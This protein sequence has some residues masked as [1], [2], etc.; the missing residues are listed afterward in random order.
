MI[1]T[2]SCV[3]NNFKRKWYKIQANWTHG[4]ARSPPAPAAPPPPPPP[5]HPQPLFSSTPS[6]QLTKRSCQ[7]HLE[8]MLCVSQ[9]SLGTFKREEDK[10][11]TK[12]GSS[13]LWY[14]YYACCWFPWAE[15]AEFNDGWAPASASQTQH[16]RQQG[17][18]NFR[19][20]I[21]VTVYWA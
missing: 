3:Q 5:P 10:K 8:V 4:K 19:P 6:L 15:S 16:S 11:E 14:K 1:S 20:D 21:T 2:N 18:Y 12:T 13:E 9:H 7:K 17:S